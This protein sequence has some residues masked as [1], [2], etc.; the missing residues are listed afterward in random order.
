MDLAKA[1]P[2]N[3]KMVKDGI[4]KEI[5]GIIFLLSYYE[6]TKAKLAFTAYQQQFLAEGESKEDAVVNAMRKVLVN[7]IVLDWWD[8]EEEGKTVEYSKETLSRLLEQYT[9][10][11]ALIM[12][13]ANDIENFKL[14]LKEKTEE[15]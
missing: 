9:G 3:E 10:L 11:D 14:Q 6:G 13:E 15:K 5:A 2:A 12:A 4:K 8:M 1:F 7:F